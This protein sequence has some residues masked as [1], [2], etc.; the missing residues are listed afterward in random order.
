MAEERTKDTNLL[1]DTGATDAELLDAVAILKGGTDNDKPDNL[2]DVHG[3]VAGEIEKL[4]VTIDTEMLM[5][6]GMS[7][8]DAVK[9]A[10]IAKTKLILS[11]GG[12]LNSFEVS[13]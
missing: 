10:T 5:K 13:R 8:D 1:A 9:K 3:Y 2:T 11:I 6:D 12:E 7:Q 4:N